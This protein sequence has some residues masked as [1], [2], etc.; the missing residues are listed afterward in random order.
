MKKKKKSIK[1]SVTKNLEALDGKEFTEAELISGL[2]EDLKDAWKKLR[3]FANGLGK[4]RIYASKKSIM[5]AR[6][7]C[8]F[9]AR[10]QKKYIM[11]VKM[12]L[13]LLVLICRPIS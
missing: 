8:Y 6:K 2:D 4:Q 3:A 11:R 7:I 13:L 9:Y 5:F 10:P 1:G 12:L